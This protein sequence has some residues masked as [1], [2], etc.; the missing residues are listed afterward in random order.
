MAYTPI[1]WETGDTI[2]ADK[3][4]GMQHGAVIVNPSAKSYSEVKALFDAGNVVLLSNAQSENGVTTYLMTGYCYDEEGFAP[5]CH[6]YIA[7]PADD[8]LP[9]NS[10]YAA[11]TPADTL[12]LQIPD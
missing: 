11:E 7:Q 12:V 3:L 10:F 4:N 5:H 8:Q 1:E 6:V 2:T 9:S